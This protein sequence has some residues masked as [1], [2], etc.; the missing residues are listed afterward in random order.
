M[1]RSACASFYHEVTIDDPKTYTRPWKLVLPLTSP[2]LLPYECQEGNYML[3]N[4]LSAE[5]VED[6]AI[7]EDAGGP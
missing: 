4:V 3:P 7:E 6:R 1:R 2:Q 5:R